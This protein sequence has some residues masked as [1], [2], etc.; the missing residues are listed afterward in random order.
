MQKITT[1]QKYFTVKPFFYIIITKEWSG[2]L[3]D[4]E[5]SPPCF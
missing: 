5:D 4:W 3:I 2:I 1:S